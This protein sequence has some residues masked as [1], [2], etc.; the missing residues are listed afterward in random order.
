MDLSTEAEYARGQDLE[1]VSFPIS[2][3]SVP[4][5]RV[6]TLK[7]IE[8]LEADLA[9]GRKINVHCRQGIGPKRE[10]RPQ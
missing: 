2:D 4:E 3:R 6:S 8:R 10:S 1:F 5:S 9:D 7:L